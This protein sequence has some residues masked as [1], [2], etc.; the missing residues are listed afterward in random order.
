MTSDNVFPTRPLELRLFA[1][2]LVP[3][4]IVIVETTATYHD[5]DRR[6]ELSTIKH[7]GIS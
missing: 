1:Q 3:G 2:F 7:R 4:H 5:R 6:G